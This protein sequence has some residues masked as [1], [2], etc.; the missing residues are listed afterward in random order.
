MLGVLASVSLWRP[1][2]NKGPADQLTKLARKLDQQFVPCEAQT[3]A[4][5]CLWSSAL[6]SQS[7]CMNSLR[8]CVL[9]GNTVELSLL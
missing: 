8:V 9:Q 5:K 6:C 4:V 2:C 7:Q 1:L 3:V